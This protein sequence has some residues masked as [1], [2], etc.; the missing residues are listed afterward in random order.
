MIYRETELLI[1]AVKLHQTA[2]TETA[3]LSLVLPGTFGGTLPKEL[4]W[5]L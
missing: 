5:D 3:T 2:E 1:R 4:P